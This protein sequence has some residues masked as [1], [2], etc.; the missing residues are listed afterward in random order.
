M[1][2]MKRLAQLMTRCAVTSVLLVSQTGTMF[3]NSAPPPQSGDASAEE[4]SV[5]PG[6]MLTA[7]NIVPLPPLNIPMLKQ[8]RI[9][10]NLAI[11]VMIDIASQE[12]MQ[13]FYAKRSRLFAMY[14]DT[15][16]KW[17]AAFQDARAPAN[18]IAI[19]NQLQNATNAVLGRTDTIV[20]LQSAMVRRK[21]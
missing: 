19:K 8:N 17:A 2:K 21:G 12:S 20:L 13:E 10:G 3:A 5:E 9:V 11:E 14:A 4:A 7:P 16:G 6:E 1:A 18:V 15:L